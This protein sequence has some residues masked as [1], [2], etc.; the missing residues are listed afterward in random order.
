METT[1]RAS[2]S[3]ASRAPGYA[4]GRAMLCERADEAL[5]LSEALVDTQEEI[6]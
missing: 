1:T 4:L 6:R 5:L 3:D 2:G